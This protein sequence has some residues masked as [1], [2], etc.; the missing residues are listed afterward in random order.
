MPR[1]PRSSWD[2]NGGRRGCYRNLRLSLGTL[3]AW[4]QLNLNAVDFGSRKLLLTFGCCG[5]SAQKLREISE[6]EAH[7]LLTKYLKLTDP[8][9]YRLGT[10]FGYTGFHFFQAEEG[11]ASANLEDPTLGVLQVGYYAVDRKTADTWDTGFCQE[12]SSPT[13]ARLQVVIL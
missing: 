10:D 13:L 4:L 5:H 1:V 9:V 11:V 12:I 2:N 6:Q 3:I 7:R 8:A